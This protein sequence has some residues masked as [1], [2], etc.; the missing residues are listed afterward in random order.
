MKGLAASRTSAEMNG[1]RSASWT[2]ARDLGSVRAARRLTRATLAE[3]D[4]Q[5][6]VEV[7]ELLVS[8]LVGNALKHARGQVRLSLSVVD[9]L[10]RCEVEDEDPRLPRLCDAAVDD[11]SGRGLF[12]VDTL[13]SRWDAVPTAGG[14]VVRFDLPAY[15]AA[16][17][18]PLDVPA[19]LAA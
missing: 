6:P 18:T 9:G 14:K 12:L 11:E 3:W 7:A 10:V 15:A 4:L 1:C 19:A 8:E 13:S 2:L 5:D 16:G 17:T